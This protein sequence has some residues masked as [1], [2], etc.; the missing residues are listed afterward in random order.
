MNRELRADYFRVIAQGPSGDDA[1]NTKVPGDIEAYTIPELRH[2]S[3][4][5]EKPSAIM[6]VRQVVESA[7]NTTYQELGLKKVSPPALVQSQVEG[8]STLFK[9]DYYGE[10]AFV[11]I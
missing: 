4:R 6:F 7:F 10:T 2:L 5:H 1:F 3:L 9:F 8:G 11:A